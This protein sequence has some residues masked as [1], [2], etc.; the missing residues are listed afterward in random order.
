[1]F[2][3]TPGISDNEKLKEQFLG[4][5]RITR[6][7]ESYDKVEAGL[8]GHEDLSDAT[9][10]SLLGAKTL[11]LTEDEQKARM[12]QTAKSGAKNII[13]KMYGRNKNKW[14]KDAQEEMDSF[15]GIKGTIIRR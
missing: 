1:M 9:V 2:V 4:L 12:P 11:I 7:T 8:G 6:R 15:M 10:S 14:E 13:D 3:C 5:E